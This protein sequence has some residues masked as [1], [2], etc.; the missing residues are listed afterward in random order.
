M[1]EETAF[2]WDLVLDGEAPVIVTGAM[3]A[4]SDPND[5]G[6]ENLRNAVRCA[7]SPRSAARASASSSTARST[8]PTA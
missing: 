6:P 8:R 7:A 1:I 4:A 2:L 5:D 3:R